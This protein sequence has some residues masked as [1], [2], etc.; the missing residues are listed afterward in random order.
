V[1]GPGAAGPGVGAPG[2]AGPV[3]RRDVEAFLGAKPA[4]AQ[5]HATSVQATIAGR[6]Q[7]FTASWYAEHPNAWRYAHPYADWWAVAGAVG[8]YRWLAVPP[9]ATTA[10]TTTASAPATQPA[11]EPPADLEWMPLGVFA[12]APRGSGQAHAYQQLAVSRSGELKGNYYDAVSDAVQPIAGTI[13]RD[14]RKAAWTVGK[15]A[16][17]DTTLDALLQPTSEAT[18]TAG[19]ATQT[20]ELTQMEKP[21]AGTK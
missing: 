8:V 16:R 17:F 5:A 6:T 18:M 1:G 4:A 21:A 3:E 11:A 2:A 14:T 9:P 20:W 15:G 19:S 13:D 7:P 12:S 10:G